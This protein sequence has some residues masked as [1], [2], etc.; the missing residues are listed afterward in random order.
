MALAKPTERMTVLE[1]SYVPFEVIIELRDGRVLRAGPVVG[2]SADWIVI[3]ADGQ[4][5]CT[6]ADLIKTLRIVAEDHAVS[7]DQAPIDLRPRQL[8]TLIQYGA[9]LISNLDRAQHD[10]DVGAAMKDLREWAEATAPVRLSPHLKTPFNRGDA[11]SR[12]CRL[13]ECYEEYGGVTTAETVS[14]ILED[15]ICLGVTKPPRQLSDGRPKSDERRVNAAGHKIHG[16]IADFNR[17]SSFG[18]IDGYLGRER[19][20][21]LEAELK[22]STMEWGWTRNY[23]NSYANGAE[24]RRRIDEERAQAAA[25]AKAGEGRK[26]A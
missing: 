22:G 17:L 19:S 8:A 11:H 18:W 3:M 15:I 20:A 10:S 9:I 1:N 23:L 2:H 24:Q 13:I 12:V 26:G 14:L 25:A 4:E 5:I 21:E 7:D 16:Y 6:P